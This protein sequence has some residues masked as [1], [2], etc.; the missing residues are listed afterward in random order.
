MKKIIALLSIVALA[1][2]GGEGTTDPVHVDS[3][4]SDTIVV[5]SVPVMDSVSVDAA[6]GGGSAEVKTEEKPVK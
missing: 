2:C 1:S 5:D 4:I 3:V 6:G